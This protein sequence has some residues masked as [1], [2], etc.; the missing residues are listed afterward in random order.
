MA[1]ADK[2]GENMDVLEQLRQYVIQNQRV[3]GAGASRQE[4]SGGASRFGGMLSGQN[5]QTLPSGDGTLRL[6]IFDHTEF[7]RDD[8]YFGD[9]PLDAEI[10]DM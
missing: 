4:A 1:S 3:A 9:E 2:P 8:V 5:A 10:E 7:D 6:F